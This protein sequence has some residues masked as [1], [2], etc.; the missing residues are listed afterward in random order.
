[1]I[2]SVIP[3]E[4]ILPVAGPPQGQWTFAHWETLPD[5]GNRYEIIDGVLYMTTAPSFFHQWIVFRL[6]ELVGTPAHTQGIAFPA[7]APVAVIMPG[8]DPV[9]PDFVMV[10]NKRASIIRDKR[11]YG[12]PDLIVE[13]MSPGSAIYDTQ[14]KLNAYANAGVPEYAIIDPRLRTL[15]LYS[16]IQPHTYDQPQLFANTDQVSFACLPAITFNVNLLFDG[17]PDSSL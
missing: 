13:I 14:I 12:V 8:C 3:T 9:Q 1:M 6:I 7:V 15:S 17:S 5:D 4:N 2:T 10:L 16:L 11:I